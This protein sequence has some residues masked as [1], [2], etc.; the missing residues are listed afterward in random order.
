MSAGSPYVAGRPV[1]ADHFYGR[2]EQI[3]FFLRR[4][5]RKYPDSMQVLGARRAGKTSFLQLMSGS[6]APRPDIRAGYPP[7]A[8]AYVDLLADVIDPIRFR[9][10][11]TNAVT[12]V[13]P[14][15]PPPDDIAIEDY[16][17]FERWVKS[18]ADGRRLVI[19]LD[20]FETLV[21]HDRFDLDFFGGL[22]ALVTS[23]LV[24]WVTSSFRP[25]FELCR[26]EEPIY[27]SEFCNVFLPSPIVLGPMPT[28]E[29][30]T[31]ITGPAKSVGIDL[32]AEEVDAIRRIGGDMPYFL[33]VTADA[34]IRTRRTGTSTETCFGE[35]IEEL[36]GWNSGLQ[37]LYRSYWRNLNV[38]ERKCLL[39]AASGRHSPAGQNLNPGEARLLD[40]GLLT[41]HHGIL[42]PSGEAFRRWIKTPSTS[43]R[44]FI[45][46]G[47]SP[48]WAQVAR[49][50]EKKL[51]L[52]TVE[53]ETQSRVGDAI[54]PVLED[55]LEQAEFAILVL[56]AEDKTSDGELRARE[57]VIH[58]AGLFQGK[59][60]FQRVALLKQKGLGEISNLAGLQFIEFE[61]DRIEQTW[62]QLRD[63]FD[64]ERLG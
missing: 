7:V 23:E 4:I 27:V 54:V 50:V 25:L 13:I 57:N 29:A 3:A 20:E 37:G 8:V 62:E 2:Q 61:G 49:F 24:T 63:F 33:Q 10:A 34:W 26:A 39:R 12:K 51:N 53:Y 52:E 38:Q 31:L 36:L 32:T 19:L 17:G 40:L 5:S 41:I 58:E 48:L 1:D 44:V 15:A 18:V 59:L 35:V 9:Q 43:G 46:H 64:R 28:A 21:R 6:G 11:V 60:G 42:Q 30:E 56:T 55:M 14:E 47:R 45:G 16:V 22:R